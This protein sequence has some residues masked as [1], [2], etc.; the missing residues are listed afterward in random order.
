MKASKL[1]L[2]MEE[3]KSVVVAER[4]A[5]VLK[6]CVLEGTDLC[7]LLAVSKSVN[8]A[9]KEACTAVADVELII[10]DIAANRLR[11]LGFWLSDYGYLVRSITVCYPEDAALDGPVGESLF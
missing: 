1:S 7:S 5:V 2:P 9:V 10:D 4:L 8:G 6:H 11:T 3:C